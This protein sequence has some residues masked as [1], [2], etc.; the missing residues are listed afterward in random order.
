MISSKRCSAK[1]PKQTQRDV[2]TRNEHRTR[3]KQALGDVN[4]ERVIENEAFGLF[5]C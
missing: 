2:M 1:M 3:R 4:I 5:A